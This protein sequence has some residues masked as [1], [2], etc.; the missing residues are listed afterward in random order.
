MA[1]GPAELSGEGGGPLERVRR[2]AVDLALLAVVCAYLLTALVGLPLF[3]D[4]GWYFFKIATTGQV[5]LP[6]L[7]YTAVLPQLPAAWAA[8]RIADPVLLRHLFALG[9]VALPIA[10]L[11]ACWALVRRRAPV[12]FLF[13]LLWFLLNLVNFSGVSELLSCLYL[14]WPLVL[15]M[16]LAPARRWVWLAAAIVPPMLVALHPLAF[17]PAFALALLGAALAWLLPNLR[18]IWGVLAL[19]SLG[20]GL[21]RLAW[22]LVGMNDYERG[23][24]ETDS[25]INYLM[26]NTW[27]QHLLLIVVLMLGLTLGVGLLLRGRAQGLILGF[28]R[29][30][31]GL[32]PVVAVLVSVE[33]LNGEGIQLKSGVTFVV[34]LALMGLVSALVLAPPQLGWLQLPRWD[35]RLRGRTSLVMII[36]VSMVVL[37]L[38]KSAA[39]WT[40][41]RGLQNLLAESRDDCIHLSASEPFALQWPWM[42]IID[43]WVTPMNALAFRPRLILD[44]ERGI[45]PIPLLLRHDGCAVLSQT[46][47]VELVSWYVRDV[48]SLDQRFGPLRR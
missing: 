12:L 17:L 37:L 5:E 19:W 41:T 45:E 26:T 16:L 46:G 44:A 28:A 47:K 43:D 48:H 31:A 24:L 3:Q 30:L 4:G 35:P 22:T 8:S 27:G 23:R 39:W 42:R 1:R 20:S 14:T 25:A 34:G 11:L 6:N 7:R 10:S 40:A 9:Y 36:A 13:P 32:V 33:I 2:G 15:A 38:A 29:V 21:L 18:R